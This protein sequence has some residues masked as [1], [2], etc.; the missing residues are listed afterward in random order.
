MSS[1]KDHCCSATLIVTGDV[2]PDDA[3]VAIGMHFNRSWRK[4]EHKSFKC[5]DG[6]TLVFESICEESGW[7][8]FLPDGLVDA[9][10]QDQLQHWLKF[11]S[12]HETEL[13]AL[14]TN[15]AR[16]T[17]DLYVSTMESVS[18]GPSD[19]MTLGRCGVELEWTLCPK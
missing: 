12:E 17:L 2:L 18:I 5:P 1:K 14:A 7:R 15:G 11:F 3:F 19:L 9:P 16:I 10:H 4:G 6:S 13:K 8:V